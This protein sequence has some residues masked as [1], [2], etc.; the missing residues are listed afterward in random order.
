MPCCVDAVVALEY[1]RMVRACDGPVLPICEA[2]N[3]CD[4]AMVGDRDAKLSPFA[5]MCTGVD[6]AP[7]NFPD[8]DKT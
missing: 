2:L 5:G 1:L 7:N 8:K 3:N 4:S 6:R